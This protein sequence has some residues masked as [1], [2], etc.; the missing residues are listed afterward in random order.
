M[1][2]TP[3]GLKGKGYYRADAGLFNFDILLEITSGLK[4]VRG[5][6]LWLNNPTVKV[7]KLDAPDNI[8]RKALSRIQPLVDLDRVP[9]PLTLHKVE[10]NQGSAVLSTVILPQVITKGF[11]YSY[12]K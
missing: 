1:A 10:L 12:K 5:K 8:T 6:E 11:K 2:I 3:E 7:N 4:I 9:L